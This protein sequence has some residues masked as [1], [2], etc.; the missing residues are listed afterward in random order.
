ME[1]KVREN[2][3]RHKTVRYEE[4]DKM[5]CKCSICVLWFGN[6]VKS[7]KLKLK[8]IEGRDFLV[9]SRHQNVDT[10]N[11]REYEKKNNPN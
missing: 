11:R 5:K 4:V 3:L 8:T 7:E 10:T 9:C 6:A 1:I 2:L